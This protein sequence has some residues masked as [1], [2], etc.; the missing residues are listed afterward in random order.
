MQDVKLNTAGIEFCESQGRSCV[1]SLRFMRLGLSSAGNTISRRRPLGEAGEL[2]SL[3][4][5]LQPCGFA[6]NR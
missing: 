3:D 1:A 5:E 2:L 4:S 6:A